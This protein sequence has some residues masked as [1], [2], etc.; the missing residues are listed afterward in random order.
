MVPLYILFKTFKQT[1]L[2]FLIPK[3]MMYTYAPIK[4]WVFYWSL[5]FTP[6]VFTDS[7]LEDEGSYECVAQNLFGTTL[8]SAFLSITGIGNVTVLVF[9]QSL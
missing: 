4:L 9:L 5:E 1:M 7:S 2:L 8:A 6:I 3:M